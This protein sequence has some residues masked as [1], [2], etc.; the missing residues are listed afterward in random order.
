VESEDLVV[1]W[2]MANRLQ[3]IFGELRFVTSVSELILFSNVRWQILR[4]NTLVILEMEN[5]LGNII[6]ILNFI[7]EIEETQCNKPYLKYF[8][9]YLT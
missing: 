2:F 5:A 4:W 8:E 7:M 9:I 3:M 6:T 1:R